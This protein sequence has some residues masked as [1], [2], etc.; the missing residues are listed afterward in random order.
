MCT[1][2]H[3]PQLRCGLRHFLHIYACVHVCGT[4]LVFFVLHRRNDHGRFM[5][6]NT[7]NVGGVS[8]ACVRMTPTNHFRLRVASFVFLLFCRTLFNECVT[9]HT[10]TF[11]CAL[12]FETFRSRNSSQKVYSVFSGK[13]FQPLCSHASACSASKC[14]VA[15]SISQRDKHNTITPDNNVQP[16]AWPGKFSTPNC[17]GGNTTHATIKHVT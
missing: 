16:S 14:H 12:H 15:N 2:R 1:V 4:V 5:F 3:R 10:D 11:C 17:G 6:S 8:D 13:M 9:M 7:H